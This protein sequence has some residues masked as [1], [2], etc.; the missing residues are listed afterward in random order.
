[1]LAGAGA[2]VM[3][4]GF[5]VLYPSLALL[6]VNRVSAAERGAALGAF[7]A[8]FDTGVGLGAPLAG[9]IAASAGYAAAFWVAAAG[10][11]LGGLFTVA[12]A[13]HARAR[14]R[15]EAIAPMPG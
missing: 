4:A 2:I 3:G 12:T 1:V 14:A 13:A 9:A 10:A 5:S 6:V 8:F 11:A 15:E 7:T